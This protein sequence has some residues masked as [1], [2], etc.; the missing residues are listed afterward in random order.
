M[1][2]ALRNSKDPPRFRLRH[3]SVDRALCRLLLHHQDKAQLPRGKVLL[4][5]CR[6]FV[7]GMGGVA[8]LLRTDAAGKSRRNRLLRRRRH[9]L[10]DYPR[11]PGAANLLHGD[12]APAWEE[13]PRTKIGSAAD[14]LDHQRNHQAGESSTRI[15]RPRIIK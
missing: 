4:R 13:K 2:L 1:N 6:H 7:G 12:A 15:T 8:D 14:R 10:L 9:S 5:H 3:I 11:Y